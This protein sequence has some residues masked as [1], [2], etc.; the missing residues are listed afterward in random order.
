MPAPWSTGSETF[1]RLEAWLPGSGPTLPLLRGPGGSPGPR[2][3]STGQLSA[4]WQWELDP[5]SGWKSLQ[6]A[7]V[8]RARGFM[9]T[10]QVAPGSL[11]WGQV[12]HYSVSGTLC[13][14]GAPG[15]LNPRLRPSKTG[16]G[17]LLRDPLALGGGW[18]P[19]LPQVSTGCLGVDPDLGPGRPPA[20]MPGAEPVGKGPGDGPCRPPS[21]EVLSLP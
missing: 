15:D 13:V 16:T 8:T 11:G 21:G 9:W 2:A 19:P 6:R 5:R 12:G 20:R 4:E 7:G 10:P 17:S 1:L 3:A 14:P 18:G